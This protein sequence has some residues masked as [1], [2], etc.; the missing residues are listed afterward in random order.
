M[1]EETFIVEP[2][3]DLPVNDAVLVVFVP[4]AGTSAYVKH[5]QV[6]KKLTHIA[7]SYIVAGQMHIVSKCTHGVFDIEKSTWSQVETALTVRKHAAAVYDGAGSIVITGGVVTENNTTISGDTVQQLDCTSHAVT[8]LP[9][10]NYRRD[11]HAC[12]LYRG[13]IMVIGGDVESTCEMLVEKGDKEKTKKWR[14]MHKLPF[15]AQGGALAAVVGD[16]ICAVEPQVLFA[17]D[18]GKCIPTSPAIRAHVYDG[19]VWR[20]VTAFPQHTHDQLYPIG[21]VSFN[22]RLAVFTNDVEKAV[23]LDPATDEWSVHDLPCS[24]NNDGAYLS[25][26][27]AISY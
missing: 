4:G 22:D 26:C 12:V 25:A 23:L 20:T 14:L 1:H 13:A 6:L 3:K 5:I 27:K 7:C 16:L 19:D 18:K 15:F 11:R 9:R 2:M 21:C 8:E 24:G 17:Y 10:M